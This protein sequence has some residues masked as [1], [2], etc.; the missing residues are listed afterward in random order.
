LA[1]IISL[2]GYPLLPVVLSEILID[3]VPVCP[4][5]SQ[6]MVPSPLTRFHLRG[7]SVP[8]SKPGLGRRLGA[9]VSTSLKEKPPLVSRRG[10]I[11]SLMAIPVM[12][13]FASRV[14]FRPSPVEIVSSDVAI[15]MGVAVGIGVTIAVGVG[16]AVGVAIGMGVAVG[17]GIGVAVSVSIVV[18]VVC[19]WLQPVI[20][21]SVFLVVGL[22]RGFRLVSRRVGFCILIFWFLQVVLGVVLSSSVMNVVLV[23][24]VGWKVCPCFSGSV[25]VLSG[26]SSSVFGPSVIFVRVKV[27]GSAVISSVAV[28]SGVPA[29]SIMILSW[30]VSPGF[31]VVVRGVIHMVGGVLCWLYAVVKVVRS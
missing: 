13:P 6:E 26:F 8:S 11:E 7:V 31:I 15:G 9:S 12:F 10:M 1:G 17:I 14:S 28:V 27:F 24:G 29:G 30:R 22:G 23:V 5:E 21:I 20:W 2:L 16:V 3:L 18:C 19:V 4:G 25:F